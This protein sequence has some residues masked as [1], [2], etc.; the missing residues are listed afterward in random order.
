MPRLA[1]LVKSRYAESAF[2]G[3]GARH[4]G[5]RWNSLGQPVVYAADSIALAA[6]ELLVHLGSEQILSSYT[7]FQ[8][9]LADEQVMAL[10]TQ[11]LPDDWTR[12]PAVPSTA[13]IGDEWLDSGL[14]V[15]LRVP[16]VIVPEESNYLLNPR[17]PDF[18]QALDDLR[19]RPFGFDPRLERPGEP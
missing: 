15:A 5:G 18:H 19:R 13:R 6:L 17:Y 10:D 7:L 14:S 11:S 8:W 3:E 4:F 12:E 1:R 16:S 2:D 9:N